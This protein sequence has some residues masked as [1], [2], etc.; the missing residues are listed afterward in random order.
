MTYLAGILKQI[1][2][3]YNSFGVELR[4]TCKISGS[5]GGEYEDVLG[6]CVVMMEAVNTSETSVNFYE[7]TRR[8][9]PEDSHGHLRLT[10]LGKWKM[11]STIYRNK[12]F[13]GY[14][15][16]Q[17]VLE[18]LFFSPFS[19]LTRLVAREDFIILSRGESSRSYTIYLTK[20]V[21]KISS[22]LNWLTVGSHGESLRSR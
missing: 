10:Y 15:P 12:I 5:H 11:T 16:H 3:K 17:L 14:Q 8:N 2:K 20:H 7:T 18:T 21:V 9:I 19:Q 13:S 6:C 4:L 1:R 22:G